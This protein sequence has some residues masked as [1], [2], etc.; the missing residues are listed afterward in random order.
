MSHGLSSWTAEPSC[1]V[2]ASRMAMNGRPGVVTVV[3]VVAWT[4][5]LPDR[6]AT[7]PA[8]TETVAGSP[9]ASL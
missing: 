7:A 5:R 2:A 4:A 6:S 1:R 3:V 9:T 8:D